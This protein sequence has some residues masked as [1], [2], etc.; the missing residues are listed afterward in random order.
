M[1]FFLASWLELVP[2]AAIGGI[3]L[4]VASN[5]VKPA[6]IKE[7]WRHGR[8]ESGIMIYTAV[9][10]PLTDFLV[11][12]LSALVIYAVLYRFFGKPIKIEASIEDSAS[13][14]SVGVA[15]SL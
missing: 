4:W 13:N 8:F 1:A 2:M 12:V 3:L 7:V 5:M 15:G 6:E 10:V 9:M 11:G 14:E